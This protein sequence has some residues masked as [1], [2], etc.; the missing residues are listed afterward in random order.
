MKLI[1]TTR[2][3]T[4]L[5]NLSRINNKKTNRLQAIARV[6]GRYGYQ[7]IVE[8]NAEA[9]IAAVQVDTKLLKLN[10]QESSQIIEDLISKCDYFN[11]W[12]EVI[13]KIQAQRGISGLV[14]GSCS[15]G[16]CSISILEEH[17]SL[18]L[19]ESDLLLLGKQKNKVIKFFIENAEVQQHK[20]FLDK[21]GFSHCLQ[22]DIL[23]YAAYYQWATAAKLM[24]NCY[25]L[26]LVNGLNKNT[27]NG[28]TKWFVSSPQGK[29]QF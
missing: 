10:M 16:D 13:Y 9:V 14:E 12:R 27:P 11:K 21:K 8:R 7:N 24:D 17:E 6:Y 23:D 26:L 5:N 15:L 28:D 18:R 22:E 19:I 20:F 4:A 1:T 2:L 25:G 29:P 3:I